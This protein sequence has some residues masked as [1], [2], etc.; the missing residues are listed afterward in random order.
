MSAYTDRQCQHCPISRCAS[1][2]SVLIVRRNANPRFRN[3]ASQNRTGNFL[4]FVLKLVELPVDATVGE[5]L[6]VGADLAYPSLVHDDDFVSTLDRAQ[7][8]G[9][10]D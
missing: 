4:V 3:F 7:A 9:N 6:L 8:V 10:D 1:N 5:Q 2:C